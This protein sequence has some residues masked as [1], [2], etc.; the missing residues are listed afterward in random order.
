MKVLSIKIN[1]LLPGANPKPKEWAQLLHCIMAQVEG[2]YN[3]NNNIDNNSSNN[4][5]LNILHN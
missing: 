4:N 5:N 2:V 3:N 1:R